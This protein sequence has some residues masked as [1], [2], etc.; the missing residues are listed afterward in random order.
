M[1]QTPVR[2]RK[3]GSEETTKKCVSFPLHEE[4]L[5]DDWK[6]L[7]ALDYVSES[8]YVRKLIREQA[9]RKLR[10]KSTELTEIIGV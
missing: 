2:K 1:Y 6:K 8:Q 9:N 7:A 5:I 3:W 10:G 4:N